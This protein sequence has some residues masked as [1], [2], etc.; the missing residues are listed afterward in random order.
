MG[1]VRDVDVSYSTR[2]LISGV[3]VGSPACGATAENII[4]IEFLQQFGQLPAAHVDGSMLTSSSGGKTLQMLTSYW[5][6]CGAGTQWGNV[7]LV[8]D[9]TLSPKIKWDANADTLK[10]AILATPG[11]A[12]YSPYG[13]VTAT[14]AMSGGTLCAKDA[15]RWT[16]IT[17]RAPYGNLFMFSVVNGLK[18]YVVRD[19]VNI[20]VSSYKGTKENALC[21]NH[22]LCDTTTGSC[23]C[24][25][26][27]IEGTSQY[28]YRYSS[29]NG[30]GKKGTRG[31]CGF[32][33]PFLAR[34]TM[35][36][37]PSNKA[38]VECNG[39]GLCSNSTFECKCYKS[40]FG[41]GCEFTS[42]PNADA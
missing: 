27:L 35:R 33:H 9:D 23:Q 36:A 8:Y 17:F 20:S 11:V 29:S 15:V 30:Y 39:R 25:Q 18:N 3:N 5:I 14:V 10:R 12:Q 38:G 42:C 6:K 37:C 32:A 28:L 19:P 40:F 13:N 1:T 4:T 22:G 2:Q 41:P 31:D 7:Y 34:D 16:N 26:R 21:S 24:Q